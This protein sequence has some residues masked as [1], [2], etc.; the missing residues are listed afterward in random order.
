M[1]DGMLHSSSGVSA[2]TGKPFV[3][4]TWEHMS[5]Q[6]TPAEARELALQIIEA[7]TAAE[8]DALFVRWTREEVGLDMQAAVQGLAALRKLREET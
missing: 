2:F 4:L 3:L 6:L 5:G 7:A 8:H 1:T